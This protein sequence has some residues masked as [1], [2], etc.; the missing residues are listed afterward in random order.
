MVFVI[1][2]CHQVVW[3]GTQKGDK[4]ETVLAPAKVALSQNGYGT[5][6]LFQPGPRPVM[7]LGPLWPLAR[8]QK[9]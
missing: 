2:D 9:L 3:R 8:T 1:N 5:L 7:A 4:Q 6:V